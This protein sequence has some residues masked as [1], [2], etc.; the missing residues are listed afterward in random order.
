MAQRGLSCMLLLIIAAS[1][2]LNVQANW[3]PATGHLWDYK[4]TAEWLSQH[5][6]VAV[7]RNI[8]VAECSHNTRLHFPEVQ[9]FAYF[10][11]NHADDYYHGCPY[12]TCSAFTELP[13]TADLEPDFT[14]S[15]A[16]FWH[17]LGGI[18]GVGTNPIADPKTG[19]FGYEGMN[20]AFHDG[21]AVTTEEQVDHDRNWSQK[22]LPDAWPKSLDLSKYVVTH[23]PVQ[24]ICARPGEPN[25]D[26][27]Q[28][29]G[30][31]GNYTPAPASQYFPPNPISGGSAPP[32]S[33]NHTPNHPKVNPVK[34]PEKCAQYCQCVSSCKTNA[35]CELRCGRKS[36]KCAGVSCS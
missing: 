9:V 30:A 13:T 22:P 24:P 23:G 6:P 35:P 29:P 3:D 11:V 5:P 21:P 27:G 26:P 20:G 36:K 4:P 31:Y 2:F 34:Q 19:G 28:A 18:P 33:T 17:Y 7:T 32:P 8:Q 1:L 25:H 10:A 16:F 14:N 12:G 15:H